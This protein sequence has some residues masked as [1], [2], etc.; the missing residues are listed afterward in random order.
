MLLF[1]NT[2][3]LVRSDIEMCQ[4]KMALFLNANKQCLWNSNG[5]KKDLEK[6]PVRKNSED[7]SAELNKDSIQSVRYRIYLEYPD[8]R[9]R[10]RIFEGQLVDEDAD[11]AIK[12]FYRRWY[13]FAD[14]PRQSLSPDLASLATHKDNLIVP[15]ESTQ[16][17]RIVI[18]L[19]GL[20]HAE[21]TPLELQS[22]SLEPAQKI[23]SSDGRPNTSAGE[24]IRSRQKTLIV[25]MKQ[26]WSNSSGDGKR[27][28]SKIISDHIELGLAC[29]DIGWAAEAR[30]HLLMACLIAEY[31]YPEGSYPLSNARF[32]YAKFLYKYRQRSKALDILEKLSDPLSRTRFTGKKLI[33]FREK[34]QIKLA[35]MY[36][37]ETG[38]VAEAERIY[39]SAFSSSIT[40]ETL[41]QAV[42]AFCSERIAWAQVKQNK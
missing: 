36:L 18:Q 7:S 23:E 40:K 25:N 27:R 9:L 41:P 26:I 33:Y 42:P 1:Q 4:L 16:E 39:Q 38:T 17:L 30:Y 20:Q 21:S 3:V 31:L 19:S 35:D 8:D 34:V 22:K 10:K 13:D 11:S 14:A 15:A 37:D 5:L 32:N 29:A 2:E 6:N 12:K 24:T 28:P